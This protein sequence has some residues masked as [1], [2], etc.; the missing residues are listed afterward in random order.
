ML[1]YHNYFV[2]IAEINNI[3]EISSKSAIFCIAIFH[4]Q[5]HVAQHT[6]IKYSRYK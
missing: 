1:E 5:I 6:D 4:C 3:A 2:N